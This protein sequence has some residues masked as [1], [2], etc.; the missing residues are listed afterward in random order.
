VPKFSETPGRIWR[1]P[2]KLGSDTKKVLKG[3]LNL[4]DEQIDELKAKGVVDF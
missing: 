1:G 3:L 2:P 4:S